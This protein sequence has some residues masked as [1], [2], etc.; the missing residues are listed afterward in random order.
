MQRVQLAM[1]AG[2]FSLR[3]GDPAFIPG[4]PLTAD[5]TAVG[6]LQT[7]LLSHFFQSGFLAV[8]GP[9]SPTELQSTQFLLRVE[10]VQ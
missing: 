1:G 10:S 8:D 2:P 6:G 9:Y 4:S 7:K 5:R 3:R